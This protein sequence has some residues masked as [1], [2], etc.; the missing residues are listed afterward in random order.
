M[1]RRK[2][3]KAI[4]DAMQFNEQVRELDQTV[5][6]FR[7]TASADQKEI[8]AGLTHVA[9]S[10]NYELRERVMDLVRKNLGPQQQANLMLVLRKAGEWLDEERKEL[11]RPPQKFSGLRITTR[12]AARKLRDLDYF[13]TFLRCLARD[14]L[15][16]MANFNFEKS[17]AQ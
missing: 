8:V 9:D 4:H 5:A 17:R 2:R 1:T 11:E 13:E 14:I 12:E 7:E 16:S 6:Q 10:L 3:D 15:R